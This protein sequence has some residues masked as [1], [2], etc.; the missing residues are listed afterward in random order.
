MSDN[1]TFPKWLFPTISWILGGY[2]F[3]VFH[4]IC[5][6]PLKIPTDEWSWI[7]LG[8]SVL[9]F[10]V[11]FAKRIKIGEFI[12]F[13][14]EI[15]N[16]K[17]NISEF[18]TETRQ[19]LS[20]I[21]SSIN[22]ISNIQNIKIYNVGVEK[23]KD[24]DEKVADFLSPEASSEAI[25]LKKELLFD[26]EDNITALARTRIIL[27]QLLRK[28]LG[29]KLKGKRFGEKETKYLSA[30]QLFRHFLTEYPEYKEM[31]KAFE[32]VIRICNAAIHGQRI[33]EDEATAAFDMSSRIIAVLKNLAS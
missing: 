5:G 32:Y 27:E 23:I 6:F 26:E 21:S 30:R 16:M 24:A 11:P 12:E 13:E 2:F 19:S 33:P 20:L 18:K 17:E 31:T 28:I 3:F 10:L 4:N 7:F 15:K 1:N 9:F 29:K 25:S 22:T 8:L 14:R